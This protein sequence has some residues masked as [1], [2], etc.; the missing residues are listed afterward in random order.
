MNLRICGGGGGVGKMP[1]ILRG[2]F[3]VII[4][5]MKAIFHFKM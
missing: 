4:C 5:Q 1:G 3:K 2:I